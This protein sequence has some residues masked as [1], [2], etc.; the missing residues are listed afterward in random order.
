MTVKT[1]LILLFCTVHVHISWMCCWYDKA[2][3]SYHKQ[4]LL[5]KRVTVTI[6]LRTYTAQEVCFTLL[7]T[8]CM[9]VTECKSPTWTCP[10]H[11]H[12]FEVTE[13]EDKPHL[14]CCVFMDAIYTLKKIVL[15]FVSLSFNNFPSI[16]WIYLTSEII[17]V[18]ET[19]ALCFSMCSRCIWCCLDKKSMTC[20]HNS[21]RLIDVLQAF[22]FPW[23]KKI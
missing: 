6:R 9:S 15:S 5:F 13:V 1:L 12:S 23:L 8:T 3:R 14:Q 10:P 22:D 4:I 17:R 16:R 21:L 19:A 7:P 20:C 11:T 18:R 2:V